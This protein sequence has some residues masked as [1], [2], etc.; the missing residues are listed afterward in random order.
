MSGCKSSNGFRL[1]SKHFNFV[2][3]WKTFG[4]SS[5]SEL[6][7]R[8][9][10]FKSCFKRVIEV[11]SS[12]KGKS[13]S[14]WDTWRFHWVCDPF[15]SSTDSARVGSADLWSCHRL[16]PW[17]CFSISLQGWLKASWDGRT[18]SSVA[19]SSPKIRSVGTPQKEC[20]PMAARLDSTIRKISNFFNDWNRAPSV[21][22]FFGFRIIITFIS[23]SNSLIGICFIFPVYGES[24]F[25]CFA[26]EGREGKGGKEG[27]KVFYVK[28]N[29]QFAAMKKKILRL[30]F[31]KKSKLLPR[32]HV[33]A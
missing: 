31:I 20:M 1:R 7:A 12:K 17:Y 11:E 22:V 23:S 27:R 16:S 21:S 32:S 3:I 5:S 13:D 28:I 25:C 30:L 29:K 19:W 15:C 8:L 18:K 2:N 6:S 9:S 10:V 14:L 24:F 26:E 4:A 33:A